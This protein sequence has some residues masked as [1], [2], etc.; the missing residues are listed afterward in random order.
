VEFDPILHDERNRY[1]V[2]LRVEADVPIEHVQ[3]TAMRLLIWTF[4]ALVALVVLALGGA[5]TPLLDGDRAQ[6][7]GPTS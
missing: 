5:L 6:A 7:T 2:P 4:L 3:A 1:P